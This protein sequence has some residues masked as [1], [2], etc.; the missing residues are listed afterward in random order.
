MKRLL[1][2]SSILLILLGV[3]VSAHAYQYGYGVAAIDLGSF[4]VSYGDNGAD[5]Y[6]SSLGY[7]GSAGLAVAYDD[8]DFDWDAY[9][10]ETM[11][12]WAVA[13]TDN[14]FAATG[15]VTYDRDGNAI[16]GS[17]AAAQA[18]NGNTTEAGAYAGS[19]AAGY[20]VYAHEAG[21]ITISVDY[22]LFGEVGGDGTG[23]AEAGSGALL[24]IYEVCDEGDLD[25]PWRNVS[26]EYDLNYY[27]EDGKLVATVLGLEKG[28]MFNIFVGT[29]AYAFAEE[30]APVPE[31]ASMLLLGTGLLGLAG[32]GRK[33][34][35]KK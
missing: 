6:V 14:S 12:D 29:A 11:N 16:T 13:Y 22:Y 32:V 26:T 27:E 25:D 7:Y 15:I 35:M 20:G 9:A 3:S 10:T 2:L 31:P 19:F 4:D 18:G 30:T 17:V 5:A 23:Y 8:T 33:K 34:L 21:S 1:A 24:G 28:D